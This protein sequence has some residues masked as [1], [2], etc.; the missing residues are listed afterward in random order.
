M[1]EGSQGHGLQQQKVK[2][3]S[4]AG[5]PRPWRDLAGGTTRGDTTNTATIEEEGRSVDS[6]LMPEKDKTVTNI[7]TKQNKNLG[8]QN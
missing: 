8:V 5:G 3:L 6:P 4:N 7:P 2:R 1:A